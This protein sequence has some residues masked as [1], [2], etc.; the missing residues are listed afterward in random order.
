[1]VVAERAGAAAMAR[2]GRATAE[3]GSLSKQGA[4]AL[5]VGGI[6]LAPLGPRGWAAGASWWKL[7]GSRSR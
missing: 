2:G 1:V 5:I 3:G 6:G 4:L 7:G